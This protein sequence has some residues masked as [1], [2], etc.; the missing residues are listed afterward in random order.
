MLTKRVRHVVVLL[1][2]ALSVAVPAS[3]PVQ[4]HARAD[5]PARLSDPEFWDL[6]EALS[7]DNGYFRSD[8][9]L[10]NESGYQFVLPEMLARVKP[11]MVY[12]GVA[13]EINFT[14]IAAL[15][16]K[17]AFIIDIRRGN[18]H[19]HLLYKA[20]FEMSANRAE[21]L[22]K[23]FSR[24]KPAA[25]TA[26]SS[27]DEMFAAYDGVAASEPLYQE[28]LKAVIDWLSRKHEFK[29]RDKS[30]AA[31][32]DADGIGYVYR[33]AFFRGGPYLN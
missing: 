28:N 12:I 3:W 20:L 33:E 13:P 24:P 9:F 19:E 1:A 32:S 22:S 2:L 18:L 10:S 25:L 27:I 5:L 17:M 26:S 16:P 14:Y 8:N 11:G 29:L 4:L 23:L 6:T 7:E 30:G 31:E 15:K 21:F